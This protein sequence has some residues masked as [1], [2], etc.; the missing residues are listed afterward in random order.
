MKTNFASFVKANAPKVLM[1]MFSA[2][3]LTINAQAQNAAVLDIQRSKK[4]VQVVVADSA[5]TDT[6]TYTRTRNNA[7]D[8]ETK[9]AVV[10]GESYAF[11]NK[12]KDVEGNLLSRPFVGIGGGASYLFDGNELRPSLSATIGWEKKNMLLFADFNMS[13]KGHNNSSDTSEDGVI[14][15][16]E[17][18]GRYNTFAATAN[19]GWKVWQSDRYRSY[20]APFAGAGYGYCKT[21]GDADDVRYTSSFY[22]FVWQGGVI[23]K[24]GFNRHFGVGLNVHVGNAA[25]NYHDSEQDMSAIKLGAM[26]SLIYTF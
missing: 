19:I 26:A 24:I 8:F 25:R 3:C 7:V 6:I 14:K 4:Q 18:S 2:L 9:K 10:N 5:A 13:W 16:A 11:D 20:V 1:G 12:N 22:G 23:A 21:D 17:V 15:G